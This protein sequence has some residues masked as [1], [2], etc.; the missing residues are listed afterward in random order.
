M[1][2]SFKWNSLKITSNIKPQWFMD[3]GFW[4]LLLSL[5]RLIWSNFFTSSRVYWFQSSLPMNLSQ[6]D[7]LSLNQ[8]SYL[9]IRSMESVIFIACR[10]LNLSF[11]T[12]DSALHRITRLFCSWKAYD[13][14][15]FFCMALPGCSSKYNFQLLPYLLLS[16]SV[17]PIEPLLNLVNQLAQWI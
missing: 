7:L 4:L 11:Q 3:Y 1:P 15:I 8:S 17:L 13:K 16:T 5:M 2:S 12:R 10:L 6:S 9:K 14:F